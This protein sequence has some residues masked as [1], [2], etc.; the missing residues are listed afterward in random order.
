MSTG[1]GNGGGELTLKQKSDT[2]RGM[3][4]KYKNQIAMALPRH[5]TP[6]RMIRVAMTTI[7]KVPKLLQCRPAEL[8]AKVIEASQL[9]LEP[10][11]VLGYA[12]LVPFFNKKR[13]VMEC[14]LIPGYKGL[15]MLARRS[16]HVSTLYAKVVYQ[17]D[18]Y[19]IKYG[20]EPTLEHTPADSPDP[21]PMVAVYA[22]CRL[23]DGGVQYEWMWTREVEAIRKR[24]RAANDG[25]WV[26]DY[27]EMAKKTALRRLCK[28]LPLS[29]E[30]QRVVAA[31]EM[32]DAGV[33]HGSIP[34]IETSFLPPPEDTAPAN[35][36]DQ[37]A[38]RLGGEPQD[39]SNDDAPLP[40]DQLFP[41]DSA[42]AP[43]DDAAVIEAKYVAQMQA[44]KMKGDVTRIAGKAQ[45]D[46]ALDNTAK[47][48]LAEV[49]RKCR[50][51]L[52]AAGN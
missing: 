34:V 46:P 22:V 41:D 26:T 49:A 52:N 37:L 23:K 43:A 25:P 9:G 11:G 15:M 42:Q 19:T 39:S 5:I 27:E 45:E 29:P 17:E 40:D 6:E 24:S 51:A 32:F 10:D 35:S 48:R 36:L 50:A 28:S 30:V 12:Y 8:L 47:V 1:N 44:A 38:D 31:D 7:Q 4:D 16:G 14:Q 18:A 2:V 20:I 33:G 13:D 3:L 21:G